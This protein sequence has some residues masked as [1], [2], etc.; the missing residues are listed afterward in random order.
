MTL[1]SVQ[2]PRHVCPHRNA[3]CS[4]E[5]EGAYDQKRP[6]NFCFGSGASGSNPA[7][8]VSRPVAVFVM[9]PRSFSLSNLPMLTESNEPSARMIG[10]SF[11]KGP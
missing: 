11:E 3:F 4:E 7:T 1:P 9:T 5:A 2:Q 10:A 6:R 8:Y